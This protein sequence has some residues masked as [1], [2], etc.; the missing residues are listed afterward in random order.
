MRTK[1][2]ERIAKIKSDSIRKGWAEAFA[3][4]A[5]EGED[6][7]L[8]ETNHPTDVTVKQKLNDILLAVSW[9]EI[10][11]Q[12]FRKSSAW[13]YHMLDGLDDKG[14]PCEFTL[15]EQ[16]QLKQALYDLADRVRRA[17]DNL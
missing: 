5:A 3:K 14:N 16:Q 6:E 12:Y 15:K 4:Y 9:R 13:L 7:M 8:L 11:N 17:A 2:N 1:N 10:S